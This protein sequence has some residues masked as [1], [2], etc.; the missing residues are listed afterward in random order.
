MLTRG[1]PHGTT[2]MHSQKVHEFGTN[3]V[4]EGIKIAKYI[5]S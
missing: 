3:T 2:F 1:M 5:N 4:L